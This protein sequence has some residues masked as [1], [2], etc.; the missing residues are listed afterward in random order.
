[1]KSASRSKRHDAKDKRSK[2]RGPEEKGADYEAKHGY[3]ILS[4]W[5]D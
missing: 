2:E 1:M 5:R 4:E 3:S